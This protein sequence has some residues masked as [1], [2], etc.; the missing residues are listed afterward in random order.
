MESF[1]RDCSP[2]GDYSITRPG[3]AESGQEN[4]SS[5]QAAPNSA[6]GGVSLEYIYVGPHRIL[7]WK[8]QTIEETQLKSKSF[9]EHGSSLF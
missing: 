6:T 7:L 4:N 1:S 5:N 2:Q 9:E 3:I 8:W